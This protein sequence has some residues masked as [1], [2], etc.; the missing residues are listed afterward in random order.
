MLGFAI[1]SRNRLG[2]FRHH[3]I[4]CL[5]FVGFFNYAANC[6]AAQK[7][8]S[9]SLEKALKSKDIL[10]R[11]GAGVGVDAIEGGAPQQKLPPNVSKFLTELEPADAR[12]LLGAFRKGYTIIKKLD[13]G[14]ILARQSSQP[15]DS[16]ALSVIDADF[17]ISFNTPQINKN[18]ES[19]TSVITQ[20][21]FECKS[22]QLELLYQQFQAGTFGTGASL[23][24]RETTKP[25]N[26][27]STSKSLGGF[28]SSVYCPK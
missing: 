18:K 19:Y 4:F 15:L 26:S 23:L 24:A 8:T 27:R 25:G 7:E 14:F 10:D 5:F 20:G 21:R 11:N 3:L 16:T 6:V 9:K 12:A 2:C 28:L 17:M 13:D 1:A 22:A